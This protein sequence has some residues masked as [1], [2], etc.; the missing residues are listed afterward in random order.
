MEWSE[1]G[2]DSPL[3]RVFHIVERTS[4]LDGQLFFTPEIEVNVYW[5][6]LTCAPMRVVERIAITE[7]ASSS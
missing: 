3:W 7:Q 2:I 5:M 1:V 6:T 4:A